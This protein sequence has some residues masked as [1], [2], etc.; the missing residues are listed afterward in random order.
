MKNNKERLCGS[1][2]KI[3]EKKKE[4][5]KQLENP[6]RMKLVLFFFFF[7]QF[8]LFVNWIWREMKK[9]KEKKHM[10]KRRMERNT[11]LMPKHERNKINTEWN[12]FLP[13]VFLNVDNVYVNDYFFIS[14]ASI[15]CVGKEVCCKVSVKLFALKSSL[16]NFIS[17][18][19]N[20]NALL[21]LF[22]FFVFFSYWN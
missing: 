18:S 1:N 11:L 9:K 12:I 6:S 16:V 19:V 2:I 14:S 8:W 20:L 7:L 22:L 5:E 21:F 13:K 17:Y 4:K 10:K 3:N 15:K